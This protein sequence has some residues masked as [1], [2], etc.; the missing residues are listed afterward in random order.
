LQSSR[1]CLWHSPSPYKYNGR[2]RSLQKRRRRVA[3]GW[4][5]VR[6]LYVRVPS[7]VEKRW[8]RLSVSGSDRPPSTVSY[9][10]QAHTAFPLFRIYSYTRSDAEACRRLLL[11]VLVA[12]RARG[13]VARHHHGRMLIE[14]RGSGC[15]DGP[16][17]QREESENSRTSTFPVITKYNPT[18]NCT[19]LQ[20][21][22]PLKLRTVTCTYCN[23]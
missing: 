16:Q 2:F 6:Y 7:T 18:L 8:P 23:V 10:V 9:V 12:A 1:F 3:N 11:S 15:V 13:A 4:Y 22:R 19:T 20:L 14:G 17:Q 5:Q 21:N